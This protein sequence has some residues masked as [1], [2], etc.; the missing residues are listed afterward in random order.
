MALGNSETARKMTF[1]TIKDGKVYARTP[2]GKQT[3]YGFIEGFIRAITLKD[4]KTAAGASFKDWFII[5]DDPETGD[6]YTLAIGY[7]SSVMTSIILCLAS[8][9]DNVG[10][11]VRIEPYTKGKYTNVAVFMDG[12]RLDWVTCDLPPVAYHEIAGQSVKDDTERLQ[13][14][15]EWVQ[16]IN[17]SLK[18][19][20]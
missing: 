9:I 5:I 14:I 19:N 17:D 15:S 12:V 11:R 16:R 20:K 10:G 7:R 3:A 4:R 13:Y 8:C 1:T 2:D 18:R 6:A